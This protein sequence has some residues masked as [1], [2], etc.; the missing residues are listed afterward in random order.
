ML[1]QPVH[2]SV[3]STGYGVPKSSSKLYPQTPGLSTEYTSRPSLKVRPIGRPV[4]PGGGGAVHT[5]LQG[6]LRLLVE[7]LTANSWRID[8]LARSRS[9]LRTHCYSYSG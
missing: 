3:R 7:F 8:C 5:T 2:T 1:L 9:L 4:G 6:A